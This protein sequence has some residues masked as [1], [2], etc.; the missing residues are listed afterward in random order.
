METK[1]PTNFWWL[2]STTKPQAIDDNENHTHLTIPKLDLDVSSSLVEFL[3]KEQNVLNSNN[4]DQTDV[5]VGSII[6]EINRVAAQSPLGPFRPQTS[7]RSIEDIMRETERI[8]MESSKS[9]EQ[10]SQR[11]KTSQNISSLRSSGDSNNSTPTPKSISP[12][13]LDGQKDHS[14][15]SSDSEYS[16]DFSVTA[17]SSSPVFESPPKESRSEPVGDSKESS[18]N[19]NNSVVV[20]AAKMMQ[21]VGKRESLLPEMENLKRVENQSTE[22]PEPRSEKFEKDEELKNALIKTLENDNK[23]LRSEILEIK[24]SIYKNALFIYNIIRVF[25]VFF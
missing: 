11:S 15:N 22:N 12:L 19:S 7:E 18:H 14:G 23:T 21:D 16:D 9:F 3:E 4:Q 13:P 10:L 20:P 1:T 5:D 2:K 6:E 8:Y 17:S 25:Q 24:V